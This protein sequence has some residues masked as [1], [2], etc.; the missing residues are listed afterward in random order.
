MR[1]AFLYRWHCRNADIIEAINTAILNHQLHSKNL[2]TNSKALYPI[3]RLIFVTV[4]IRFIQS[5]SIHFDSTSFTMKMVSAHF[6]T[7]IFLFFF[8]FTF[9]Y[10]Q[11]SIVNMINWSELRSPNKEYY[12]P[13]CVL[14]WTLMKSDAIFLVHRQK[15]LCKI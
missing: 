6:P 14:N 4:K 9:F 2:N 7:I 13:V 1:L 3:S 15:C 10:Y 11:Q 5:H 8:I 12:L